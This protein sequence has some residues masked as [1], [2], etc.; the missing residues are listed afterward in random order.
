M[1]QLAKNRRGEK[2][3]RFVQEEQPFYLDEL[4]LIVSVAADSTLSEKGKAFR[5]AISPNTV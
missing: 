5:Q 4:E 3:Q 2:Q 1:A